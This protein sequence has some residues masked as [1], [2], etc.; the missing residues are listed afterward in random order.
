MTCPSPFDAFQASQF[1]AA[2]TWD[3]QCNWSAYLQSDA[4]SYESTSY[5][6]KECMSQPGSDTAT[7][8]PLLNRYCSSAEFVFASR[9]L[10][11][12]CSLYPNMTLNVLE[13]NTSASN[14]TISN[15]RQDD[16]RP[17]AS[18]MSSIVSTGLL[19]YCAL[20]PGCS[21]SAACSVASLSAI[22]GQLSKHGI[23]R[24][25]DQICSSYVARINPDF[26]GLGVH[27]QA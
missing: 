12:V 25:W 4:A 3:S 16:T 19:S 2:K 26:G 5:L 8:C 11:T 18:E 7:P 20:V 9:P 10:L 6:R 13:I 27:L 15:L 24:C 1:P 17:H 23:A 14:K 21:Q 22:D